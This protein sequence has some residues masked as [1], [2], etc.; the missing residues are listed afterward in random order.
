MS[1]PMDTPPPINEEEIFQVATA[2]PDGER[3]AYLDAACGENLALR[4]RIGRLLGSHEAGGFMQALASPEIEAELARLKPEEGGEMIGP[5]KLREQIG[6]GGFGTV[7]V[8]DQEKPVRRRVALK[9]IKM[10]MDTKEVIARFEQERQALAMMD[11]PNIAKVLDAGATQFGRPFFVME[12]VR[13]VKIT[14]YCDD[15]QLSTVERIGLFITVCQ[16]VQHAH[17]KGIIHRDLKPSNILV[18]VNDGRAVPKVIDF[19][20]AKA[21]QGRLTDGTIYTQ[22]QQMIGTPLYM[23]PEQAD[24]TSLDVDTRSDIYAL[25]VLLYELLTGHTPIDTAT[26][27]QAGMDEIRRIIREVDPP[28]PSM[29]LKT[30][31]GA[32]MTTAAKRR[33]TEPAKLPSALRGDIDWIVMKCLEKD[34]A[35]RYDTANGLAMDLQRH[36]D[37]EPVTARPPS[38]IY[39]FQKMVRRNKVATFA[40]IGIV[41]ALAV[42]LGLAMAALV[43]ERAA[44]ERE[45][46]QSV[47]AD[48]VATFI[49]AL[50]SDAVPVM[51]RQGN[52]RG[53]R[54]LVDTADRLATSSLSNA[55]AAEINLRIRLRSVFN[56]RFTDMPAA[57]RQVETIARLLPKV[58]DDQL[59]VPREELQLYLPVAR[60]WAGD[61]GAAGEERAMKELDT[62]FAEF[63]GRTPPARK[64]AMMCRYYQ[65]LRQSVS[66][67]W[68]GAEAAFAEA[69]ELRPANLQVGNWTYKLPAYYAAAL[70]SRGKPARAEEIVRENLKW[71]PGTDLD[72]REGY[73]L[74]VDSLTDA[75]CIQDRFADATRMLEEQRRLLASRGG[76]EADLIRVDALRG[77][78][79]ARSG[80]AR[81]ALPIFAALATNRLSDVFAWHS[82]VRLAVAVGDHESHRHLCRIGVL[83]F[84]STAEG[85]VA[86]YVT[87]GLLSQSSD[88]MTMSLARGMVERVAD[89]QDFSKELTPFFGA[90]L[91]WRE[92]RHAEALGIME[93]SLSDAQLAA[94]GPTSEKRLAIRTRCAFLRAMICAEL[95]RVEDA[96]QHFAQG[97]ERLQSALGNQPGHDRGVEWLGI[98]ASEAMRD[99]AQAIFKTKG[100][101][102]PESAAK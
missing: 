92:H 94:F 98:Y 75:L 71:P 89:A 57:L 85:Q 88:E 97:R 96:R 46:A 4:A 90:I 51:I 56:S 29:R 63:M 22:F 93:R 58:S 37:D 24:M 80:N 23:S 13:G 36:L 14:D 26:M 16:A 50:L 18:T 86:A 67:R 17:Q 5:Y 54:E 77:A 27:A 40:T 65:G 53:A 2:L 79:L 6:E 64:L 69:Y 49:N 52:V 68:D 11:H 84:A 1:T 95:G 41:V 83:Q 9:I 28:R 38:Q 81:E 72:A 66:L 82:A 33:N 100:I 74:L 99:E 39:R 43:R 61:G 73:L 70:S 21:T 62:L 25:G 12:L 87:D 45:L 47:R 44:K 102:L 31:D 76:S 10:G 20:V 8:A 78:V 30:L 19:G 101:P 15:Q 59:T 35:R 42:G 7:W 55:P 91:A 48:T 32:E 60:L 34:R 3:A